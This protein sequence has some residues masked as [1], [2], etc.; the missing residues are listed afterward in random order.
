M[1][2]QKDSLKHLYPHNFD[3]LS[4]DEQSEIV[5]Y[6]KSFDERQQK[7]YSIAKDHLGS[8]FQIFKSN[9]Y[10]EWKNKKE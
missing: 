10:K 4:P 2:A 5:T 1:K 9:G 8:S 3:Q 7:A 6:L